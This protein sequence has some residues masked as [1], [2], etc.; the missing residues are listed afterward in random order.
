MN[1]D[2]GKISRRGFL[3]ASAAAGASVL[4]ISTD[5]QAIRFPVPLAQAL[6]EALPKIGTLVYAQTHVTE[7]LDLATA[8]GMVEF[9]ARGRRLDKVAAVGDTEFLSQPDNVMATLYMDRGLR[10]MVTSASPISNRRAVFRG[11]IGSLVVL[12]NKLQRVDAQGAMVEE[13]PLQ[14]VPYSAES[15]ALPHVLEAL[16]SKEAKLIRV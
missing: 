10:C 4:A 16:R 13:P 9:A 14:D 6:E 8:L 1:R 5:V 11:E 12:P 7:S 2:G 15:V 3:T